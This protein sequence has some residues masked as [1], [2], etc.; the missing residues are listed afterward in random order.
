MTKNKSLYGLNT[1]GMRAAAAEWQEFASGEE[2][3]AIFANPPKRW[4]V[5][6]GGSNTLFTKDFDGMILHPVATSIAVVAEDDSSVIVEAEAAVV[7]DDL[8]CWAV[9]RGYAGLE[10]LSYIP[11]MVGASPVQ[12]IGAY[13]TEVGDVIESVRYFDMETLEIRQIEASQCRFGYRD[14]I[15]KRE[16]KGRAIVLAVVFRLS[17]TPVYNTEYGD[18]KRE[19]EEA[20]AEVS[21][22]SIRQ[23]I[24]KI[25]KYKLPEPSEIGNGGSFFKNPIVAA[26]IAEKLLAEHPDMPSYKSDCGIKIPAGWLIDRAGWKGYRRGDAGVH[27][28]QALVLVNHGTA[29]GAEIL[30]LAHEI[31]ADIKAKFGITI[32]PEVNIL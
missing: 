15:F 7:W 14:S 16:L 1:F 8:V 27:D 22:A 32:E 18:V 30:A 5:M 31:I 25:R 23:A 3:Q 11:G 26:E 24:I 28:R 4:Y 13:G 29:T 21:L 2:L 6:S 17:K 12:N 19:I 20:G 10:N 9:E